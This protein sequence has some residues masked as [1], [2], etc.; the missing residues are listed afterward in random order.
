MITRL[1]ATRYRCFEKLDADLGDVRVLVRYIFNNAWPQKT[2]EESW[3][4]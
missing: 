3:Y 2:C 4:F 1:E